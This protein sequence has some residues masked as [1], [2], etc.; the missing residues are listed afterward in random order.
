MSDDAGAKG[1]ELFNL[2]DQSIIKIVP[3]LPQEVGT[4][5]L[6]HGTM[7]S[8]NDETEAIIAGGQNNIVHNKIWKF[9]FRWKT[10]K[11]IGT[12]RNTKL[13]FLAVKVNNLNFT[14][15]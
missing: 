5:A 12:L 14:C 13:Q 9:N 4:I 10:W 1:M 15:N 6:R 7:V 2:F 8:V 11:M 3:E